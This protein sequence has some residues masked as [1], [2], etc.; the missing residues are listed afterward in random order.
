NLRSGQKL[1][2]N[3]RYFLGNGRYR[4]TNGKYRFFKNTIFIK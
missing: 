2:V 1:R 4:Q 3:G